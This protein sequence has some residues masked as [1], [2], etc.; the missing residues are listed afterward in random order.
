MPSSSLNSFLNS[1]YSE[2]IIEVIRFSK[3][4]N[5]EYSS[6]YILR[7]S[8]LYKNLSFEA[9]LLIIFLSIIKRC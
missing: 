3:T 9:K 8:L 5:I 6:S 2:G 1:L 7:L 4:F